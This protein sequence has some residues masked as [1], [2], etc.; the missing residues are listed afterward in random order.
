MNNID[1]IG[2]WLSGTCAAGLS[3]GSIAGVFVGPASSRWVF[4]VE[5]ILGAAFAVLAWHSIRRG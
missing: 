3:A 2:W 1:K 5:A 4:I